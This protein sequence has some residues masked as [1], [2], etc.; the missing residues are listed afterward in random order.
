VSAVK[1]LEHLHQLL[2]G[3]ILIKP[4]HAIN[5]V[6]GPKFVGR[7]QVSRF[8]SRFERSDEDACRIRP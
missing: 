6:V 4:N 1:I 3:S 2:R 7:I 8:G 5:D